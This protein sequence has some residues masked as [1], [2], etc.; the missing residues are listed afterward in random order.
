MKIAYSKK[1]IYS[2]AYERSAQPRDYDADI[3]K[4]AIEKIHG[5]RRHIDARAFVASSA[6]IATRSPTNTAT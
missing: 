3:V 1:R 6:R 4:D 2:R 5:C